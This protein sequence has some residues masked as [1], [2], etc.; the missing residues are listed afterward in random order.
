MFCA[1]NLVKQELCH[2]PIFVFEQRRWP[3]LPFIRRPTTLSQRLSGILCTLRSEY[4]RG[5]IPTF[6]WLLEDA[7]QLVIPILT[8]FLNGTCWLMGKCKCWSALEIRNW[9][10]SFNGILRPFSTLS[11]VVIAALTVMTVTRPPSWQWVNHWM[12]WTQATTAVLS[13]RCSLL[14]LLV[15]SIRPR[16][17]L[18]LQKTLLLSGKR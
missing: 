6:S 8:V 13:S 17:G 5:V 15:I 9:L 3:T 14:Y 7:G 4:L 18:Q 12:L 11:P 1:V 16:E 10:H 2:Q